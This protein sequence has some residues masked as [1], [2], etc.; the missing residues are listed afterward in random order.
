ML[1]IQYIVDEKG[2]KKSVIMSYTEWLKIDEL[3][4]KKNDNNLLKEIATGL[5]Q[6]KQIREGKLPKNTFEQLLY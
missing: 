2:N 3:L 6:V 5:K 4:K 1:N